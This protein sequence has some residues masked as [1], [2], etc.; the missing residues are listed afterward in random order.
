MPIERP[1]IKFKGIVHPNW[2]VGFV[3]GEGCFHVKIKNAK[4]SLG[5]QVL[6][7]FSIAQHSRD[8]FLLN[9]ITDYLGCGK[10][11]KVSTRPN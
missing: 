1:L 8:E 7:T 5:Y 2:L 9:K 10:I 3:D 4:S 6:I 11:E